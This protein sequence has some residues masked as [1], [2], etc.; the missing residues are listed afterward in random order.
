MSQASPVPA[1]RAGSRPPP[2]PPP[3]PPLR[4]APL[5]PPRPPLPPPTPAPLVGPRSHPPVLSP[6]GGGVHL[7]HGSRGRLA[8]WLARPRTRPPRG[9]PEARRCRRLAGS[10]CRALSP[11]LAGRGVHLHIPPPPPP[12]PPPDGKTG[13]SAV[14]GCRAVHCHPSSPA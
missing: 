5:P 6:P 8:G 13:T 1:L 11:V 9:I 4:G 2:P 14:A 7:A 3:R 12:P 10:G